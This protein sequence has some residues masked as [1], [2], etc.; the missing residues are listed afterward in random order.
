M[1]I[2]GC[3]CA[4]QWLIINQ[5][6]DWVRPFVAFNRPLGFHWKLLDYVAEN[7]FPAGV[8]TSVSAAARG[9]TSVINSEVQMLNCPLSAKIYS[10]C[11]TKKEAAIVFHDWCNNTAT[12]FL[13][14]HAISHFHPSVLSPLSPPATTNHQTA[15]WKRFNLSFLFGITCIKEKSVSAAETTAAASRAVS[16]WLLWNSTQGING[17]IRGA[18]VEWELVWRINAL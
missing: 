11:A 17:G 4:V 13:F 10:W 7:C 3:H 18:R 15:Y 1:L 5:E 12:M 9:D 6:T 2:L 14:L 8:T 16:S